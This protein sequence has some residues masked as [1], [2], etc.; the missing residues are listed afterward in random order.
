MQELITTNNIMTMSSLE[1]SELTG[2]RHDSVMR[3]IER[4]QTDNILL[5]TIG[6][7]YKDATGRTTFKM[8][9]PELNLKIKDTK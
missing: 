6:G 1:I 4:L 9:Y 5:A 3:T 8:I 7:E 2:S